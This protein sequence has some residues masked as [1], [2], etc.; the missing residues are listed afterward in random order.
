MPQKPNTA[1]DDSYSVARLDTPSKLTKK[2]Y[3]LQS[4]RQEL[5]RQW[6]LN[7]AFYKGKQWSYIDPN[8][9]RIMSYGTEEGQKPRFRVRIIDNQI[10]I[11]AQSLLS[12]LTKTKPVMAAT[13][14]SS[15]D[16]DVK[17]AQMAEALLE[18][19][20]TEFQMPDVMEEAILWSIVAGQ[21][22]WK[23][24][25]DDQANKSLTFA[26][27]PETGQPIV[28]ESVKEYKRAEMARMGQELPETTVYLGDIKVEALSP[29]NV[30]LDPAAK[31]FT[32]CKYAICV[33]YLTTDEIE[34]R[35]G[36]RLKP[37]STSADPDTKLPYQSSED[38][39][40]PNVK[41]VFVGY[42][43]PQPSLPKGRYVVWVEKPDDI[44]ED[45][46]WKYPTNMLPIVKFPGIR[47]PGSVYDTSPVEHS[48]PLQ[49]ELNKTSSQIVEYKNLTIKP[50]V[51]APVGSIRQR[52]TNE[53]GAV[54]EFTPIAGLRPE[55]EQLPTMPPYVFEHLK[56]IAASLQN[57]FSLQEVTEGKVPPNVEAGVAIDLLQEMATDRLAPT[58]KLIELALARAGNLMLSLAQEYYVEPRLLKIRG[59]GGSVQVRRFTQAD[60]TGGVSVVVE[61]GSGLPR[62]RA[63]RQARIQSYVEMGVIKPDHAWKY[64]DIA[65]LKGI[66][67]MF[68][69]DEDMAYREHDK[70]I[71]GEPINPMA[72]QDALMQAQT[73]FNPTTGEPF[74]SEQ[75]VMAFIEEAMVTPPAFENSSMHLET[76]GLFAKSVEF[77]ALPEDAQRRFIHHYVL[78]VQKL[79]AENPPEEGVRTN[80]QLKGTIG[81]TGAATI[82]QGKGNPTITPEIMMEPPLETWVTDSMDKPDMDEAG[83][84]PLTQMDQMQSA[85]QNE[86]K[87]VGTEQ[88]AEE[89]HQQKMRQS[90]EL[91]KA[92]LANAR[93]SGSNG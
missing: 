39:A 85:V 57:V 33:H 60:I 44:L 49:K 9:G 34:G 46:P 51:W 53:P 78:T 15:S 12:K 23:I 2:F 27:D 13:P 79:Q 24:N 55:I 84:D 82:L 65:D 31:T 48:I 36:K 81:P 71:K 92:K 72:L 22:Y 68:Q 16:A 47:V 21:G 26:I 91:H 11:G 66:S 42:F 4:G 86:E 62:T 76:H 87:H 30:Y 70:L 89:A 77:E 69:A 45:G 41:R 8:L 20:W 64:L 19:W 74:Q 25:W 37:D 10:I 80:L 38:T 61:A 18:H 75:E 83:N 50:R 56:N 93:K 6:R 32:D 52:I 5:E 40:T 28:D 29:F 73:G 58:I 43:L 35:W 63:G 7:L 54:Y 59:S 90:D 17:A 1:Q 67:K 3:Q 14:G 88:R